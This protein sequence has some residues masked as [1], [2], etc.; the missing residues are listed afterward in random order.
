[1]FSSVLFGFFSPSLLLLSGQKTN[2]LVGIILLASLTIF[3]FLL[4]FF[5]QCWLFYK[6]S[7]YKQK[8]KWTLLEIRVPREVLKTPQAMEQFFKSVHSLRNT[9]G[10]FMEKYSDGEVTLWWSFEV[11]SFGGEIHFFIR[12]PE[13]RQKMIT[14][15]LYAQYPNAEAVEVE[16]YVNRFPNKT[17]EIYRKKYNM[18]GGELTLTKADVYPIT[19]Y[20]FFEKDEEEMALDPLSALV[21]TL[22]NLKKEEDVWIQILVRP[23]GSEWQKEGKKI[24][25]ELVKRK[26]KKET[27]LTEE[28]AVFSKNLAAAPFRPPV[29]PEEIKEEKS[30]FGSVVGHLTPGEQDIVKA[31][32]HNISLPGFESL[33]RYLYFAPPE[34]FNVGFARRGLKGS[35]NQYAS[36]NL[37][38]FKSNVLVETRTRWVYYP[39]VFCPQRAEARKQRILHDYRERILPEPSW[40]GKT[41]TS[42]PLDFNVKSKSY[43]LNAAEL[44]TIYHIPAEQVLTAPHMKRSESKR[45]GPPA[46]LPMFQ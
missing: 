4:K 7:V 25:D 35:F 36:E 11:V 14:A 9:P 18:F 45:M 21:E 41:M 3:I 13:N 8:I 2:I 26:V 28:L 32:E 12:T 46:G 33:I 42:H 37:N 24:V 43:V 6:Q 20:E 27:T 44:A 22:A 10:D 1:M 23:I 31:I 16:D 34:V 5:E 19:T 39:Y 38:S 30:P 40:W 15:A 29:W 17:W